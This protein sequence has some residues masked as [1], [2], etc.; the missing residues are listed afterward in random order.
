MSLFKPN[1]KKLEEKRDIEGLV[2]CL[3]DKDPNLRLDA[4]SA[5][6]RLKDD[7]TVGALIFA[8][9]DRY[10]QIRLQAWIALGKVAGPWADS[11]QA[12]EAVPEFVDG[13]DDNDDDIRAGAAHAL[14]A[15]LEDSA[16][17]DTEYAF[18]AA[19]LRALLNKQ[20]ED[21]EVRGYAAMALGCLLDSRAVP[22]LVS[23]VLRAYDDGLKANAAVA[24]GNI[25]DVS[26][27]QALITGLAS[28]PW[29]P[30][31][32]GP[33]SAKALQKLG[34]PAIAPL[35]AAGLEDRNVHVG[36][37]AREILPK[38]TGVDFGSDFGAWDA[39]WQQHQNDAGLR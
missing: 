23:V 20:D 7:R 19:P 6:E 11:R 38:I 14:R 26:A 5:L 17:P 15:I 24:L 21:P 33:A 10:K 32:L 31:C 34:R 12:A 36:H 3:R 39:W 8:L 37:H 30:S 9:A 27:V 2:S 1:V 35:I 16:N 13:L 4:V 28:H 18:A 25:G 22:D 29:D